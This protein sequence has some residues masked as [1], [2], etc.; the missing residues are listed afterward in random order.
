MT[1]VFF[2]ILTHGH[3]DFSGARNRKPSSRWLKRKKKER[4]KGRLLAYVTDLI[5]GIAG[6][7]DSNGVHRASVC[8]WLSAPLSS[9]STVLS[10]LPPLAGKLAARNARLTSSKLPTQ[11]R[12]EPASL[13]PSILSE[14]LPVF[15]WRWKGHVMLPIRDEVRGSP[16]P[17]SLQEVKLH[18]SYFSEKWGKV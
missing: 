10:R 18:L 8:C 6:S 15:R 14:S 7:R 1:Y 9:V 4:K 11:R 12:G 2:A 5:L 13:C 16:S 3:Q 17:T